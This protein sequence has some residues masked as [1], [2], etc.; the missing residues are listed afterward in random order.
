[1][2]TTHD[3]LSSILM[4][5]QGEFTALAE[6]EISVHHF[7]CSLDDL[8][9]VYLKDAKEAGV[10]LQPSDVDAGIFHP[11]HLEQELNKLQATQLQLTALEGSKPAEPRASISDNQFA[12]EKQ[13]TKAKKPAGK[14]RKKRS[15]LP[16]GR[17]DKWSLIQTAI[18]EPGTS[19][20]VGNDS[21][22]QTLKDA[23]S[24]AHKK[25]GRRAKSSKQ[26]RRRGGA[27][28]REANGDG[29][30]ARD[31][32]MLQ[33]WLRKMD[34]Y[35]TEAYSL[36]MNNS[37]TSTGWRGLNPPEAIRNQIRRDDFSGKINATVSTFL[38]V[39]AD[40]FNQQFYLI[41]NHDPSSTALHRQV[42]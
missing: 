14:N 29:Q 1:M 33:S 37:R 27:A 6:S 40:L 8:F 26:S 32:R 21:K 16:A 38:P 25:N 2:S 12:T 41:L 35:R 42:G 36:P 39:H 7:T 15:E 5:S 4:A 34:M 24:A 19:S 20:P 3:E 9:G 23:K 30:L 28:L 18:F 13:S 11:S 10:H 31:R 17:G 22:D